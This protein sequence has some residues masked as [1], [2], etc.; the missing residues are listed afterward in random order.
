MSDGK[1]YAGWLSTMQVEIGVGFFCVIG[2]RCSVSGR[3][4][5][6]AQAK[7]RVQASLGADNGTTKF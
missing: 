1:D 2:A 6:A 4:Q 5:C 7:N 3:S